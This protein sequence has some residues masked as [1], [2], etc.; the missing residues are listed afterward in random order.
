MGDDR[1][2]TEQNCVVIF[3]GHEGVRYAA[4]GA[5]VAD[6]ARFKAVHERHEN[7]HQDHVRPMRLSEEQDLGQRQG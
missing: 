3:S 5:T 7:I 2:N 6:I 1:R 4:I